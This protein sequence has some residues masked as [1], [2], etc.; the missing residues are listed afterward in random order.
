MNGP[1]KWVRHQESWRSRCSPYITRVKYAVRLQFLATNN[2][3]KMK[4][5]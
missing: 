3:A 2:E 5:F 1:N 4:H